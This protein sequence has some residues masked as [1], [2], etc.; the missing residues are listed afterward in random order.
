MNKKIVFICCLLV[1][2]S[3]SISSCYNLKNAP[4][5]DATGMQE[6]TVIT[7]TTAA[8]IPI[9]DATQ[10]SRITSEE[11]K[12]ILG[13]PESVDEWTYEGYPTITYTYNSDNDEFMIIDDAVVRFT[14]YGKTVY[15]SNSEIFTLFGIM[16]SKEI[17]KAADTGTAL[18]YHNVSDKIADVWI[19][20]IEDKTFD[21]IKI[22]YNLNYFS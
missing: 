8:V 5:S 14:H 7:E 4:F 3:F 17:V 12:S 2:A 1:A 21:I 20:D 13:E 9:V 19:L 16:P 11:L 22:T 18:R 15:N 10:F 6:F